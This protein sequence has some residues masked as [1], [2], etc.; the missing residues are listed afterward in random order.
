MNRLKMILILILAGVLLAGCVS[1]QPAEVQPTVQPAQ[2]TGVPTDQTTKA[3]ETLNGAGATF[4]YPLISKWSS[5]YN[6]IKPDVQINY[7]SVGSGAGIK[8]ITE[9]T[10]DFGASDAPLTEQEFSNISGVLQIPESIGA[11]VV[12]YNL[13]GIQTG[14]KL[15]GDVVADIFLGKITKW[16]DP[17]IVSINSGIQLPDKD[18]I[19]AHRSDGSGT[20]FVFTDYLSAVSPDWKSKAGKGKSVNWPVGLGGK[21]NEGVAGLLSQNPYSIGY[22]ELAYA[23]LQKISYAYIRNKAGKFIEPTL[24]TT[25][26]AAAGAVQTLPAGDANWSTVSIVNAPGDNSYPIGSFTYFLAYK[27]QKDQ[28][29]GKLLA[30]FLWWAVHDGQKYSSDLLYVP[31]PDEVISINE[32]TIKLM[33]YNGQQFI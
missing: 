2:S 12:A 29:K 1:K 20:T 33:N 25:A 9:R 10:V 16:N 28:T 32:K 13:P 30:E 18:I 14:V 31:L 17:R 11:V 23:K 4:P 15:S 6:K 7:Q 22:I 8:Q 5:E 21:G 3:P 24:E 26:N 27:D 19:V